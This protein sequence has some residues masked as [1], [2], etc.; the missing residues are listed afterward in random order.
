M[1]QNEVLKIGGV[2]IGLLINK[3][4]RFEAGLKAEAD[5]KGRSGGVIG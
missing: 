5:H 3:S 2:S 4:A 1:V